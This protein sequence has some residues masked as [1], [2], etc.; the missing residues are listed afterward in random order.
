MTMKKSIIIPLLS[1]LF[2]LSIGFGFYQKT[3]ADKF[4]AVA[5]ENGKIAREAAI[6]A[7]KQMK[8]A[9]QHAAMASNAISQ[10]QVA[11][12]ELQKSKKSK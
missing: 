8:Q 9:Q 11:L 4:E 1:L 7:E 6:N 5:I 12:E 10:L 3:E 2:I